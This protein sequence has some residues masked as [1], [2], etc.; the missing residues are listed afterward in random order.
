MYV[1]AGVTGNTGS[2]VAEQ[3][4]AQG[5]S[6]RVL[7]RD[8]AKGESW[9]ARGAE[10]R[11]VA[12]EDEGALTEAIR[13][14][15]GVYALI[16][17]AYAADDVLASCRRIARAWAKA[18]EAARP[19][20][21]VFLSSI[22]AQHEDGTGIIRTLYQAEQILR[23]LGTPITFLRAASFVENWG[24]A[25]QPATTAGIVP[26][27][28]NPQRAIPTVSVV[29]IGATAARA[30]LDP[31]TTHRTLELAGPVPASPADVA[32]AFGRIFGKE[33]KVAH[34]PYE[35]VVPTLTSFGFS[36]D[37]AT[38]FREMMVGIDD[39]TV[40][41]EGAGAIAVRGSTDVEAALRRLAAPARA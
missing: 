5:K 25:L 9:K 7:V 34:A 36:V 28:E 29:D 27:F 19:R 22:G 24:S 23:P 1:V 18:I 2:I 39:G 16:P 21:V 10:V 4:L 32:A 20:H 30:L 37:V 14:A 8:A 35:A 38:R 12:L 31:P 3:L 11:V 17:P 40:S 26:T 13:G 41:F 6:V 15:E 33:V